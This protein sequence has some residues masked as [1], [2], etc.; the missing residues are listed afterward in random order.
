MA[1][2]SDTPCPAW[3]RAA[4]PELPERLDLLVDHVRFGV[5]VGLNGLDL[6][7]KYDK[8]LCAFPFQR[9][10]PR[11]GALLLRAALEALAE[12]AAPGPLPLGV[13]GPWRVRREAHDTRPVEAIPPEY[14]EWQR[15]RVAGLP[16]L[17]VP[18]EL[19]PRVREVQERPW[20]RSPTG[21]SINRS[22]NLPGRGFTLGTWREG[23]QASAEGRQIV[24][25]LLRD[26]RG[27]DGR[28]YS[29]VLLDE[30][31]TP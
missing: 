20:A 21:W 13:L 8:A 25:A 10:E 18:H 27:R 29:Y 5:I 23:P 6:P 17:Y 14:R 28:R 3:L 9:G 26:H 31:T 2:L 30:E 4:R 15:E 16:A 11:L 1:D 12:P 24:D 19:F 22:V 7:L